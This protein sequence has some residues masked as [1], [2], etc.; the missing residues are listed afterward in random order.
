MP[1]NW[2]FQTAVPEKAL[3]SPLDSKIK[4]VNPKRNQPW[5]FIGRT[6]AEAKHQYSGHLMQRADSL[7][8]ILMLGKTEGR[9]RRGRQRMRWLDGIS[10]S[11][12]TSLS[13]LRE[14]VQD[15][16]AWRAAVYGVAELDMTER[17][18]KTGT[19]PLSP[20]YVSSRA[21][22][23]LQWR[24]WG[25]WQSTQATLSRI[26]TSWSFTGKTGQLL[27]RVKTLV[28]IAAPLPVRGTIYI[29]LLIPSLSPSRFNGQ[30]WFRTHQKSF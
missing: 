21:A 18:D 19:Q 22:P 29:S 10:D 17:P 28:F 23:T 16:E 25:V 13:K 14:T 7:E 2:R 20:F 27:P 8:K 11:T 6:D 30:L 15:R 5:I 3:E 1:K 24:R 4:P 9:R 26:F 12:R